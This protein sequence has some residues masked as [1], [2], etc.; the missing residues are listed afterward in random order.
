MDSALQTLQSVFGTAAAAS[1]FPRQNPEKDGVVLDIIAL[2]TTHLYLESQWR[3][4]R[5]ELQHSAEAAA[6]LEY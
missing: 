6:Y 3:G 2:L 1:L 4:S 5:I